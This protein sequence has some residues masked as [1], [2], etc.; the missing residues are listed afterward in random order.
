ME[1]Q[2]KHV[3]RTLIARL[4]SEGKIVFAVASS[5]IAALIL[6]GKRTAHSRFEIPINHEENSTC[7]INQGTQLA[8][9]ITRASLIIWDE[10]P[11]HHR[12]AFEAVDK[13]LKDILRFDDLNSSDNPFGGK[14]VMLGGDFRQIL[15]VVPKGGRH[16]VVLASINNSYLWDYCMVFNLKT[17]MRL[18]P[19]SADISTSNSISEFSKWVLD[20]RD[21]KIESI[22]REEDGEPS[23]I[24]IPSHLLIHGGDN[25]IGEIVSITYPSFHNSYK[26]AHYLQERAILTPK[27]HTVDEINSH[28]MQ[29]VA[30]E[31]HSYLS[32]DSICKASSN[33]ADQDMIYPVEFLN[34]LHF[35]GLPNHVL[36]LKVGNPIMLLRNIKQNVGLCNGTRLIVTQLAT[37]IIEGRIITGKNIGTKVLIP[38][39]ILTATESKWPFVLRRR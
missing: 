16:E 8:K 13:T 30:G 7:S 12:Y 14:T 24:K 18:N 26:D 15:P 21:G 32:S 36:Q 31:Q 22:S 23:W 34:T 37:W 10:T 3:Y 1:G 17:N 35:S 20:I 28:M 25:P 6:Q 19:C 39:V 38:M 27:N 33:V 11:M 4:R 5:G 29:F 2:E 9:L